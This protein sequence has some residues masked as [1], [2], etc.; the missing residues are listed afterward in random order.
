MELQNLSK[1]EPQLVWKHFDEIRKTPRA[2]QQEEAMRQYI[3][4][5]AK[6]NN[7]SYDQD[8]AGNLVVSKAASK[9]KE[10]VAGTVLQTHMDMVCEKNKDVQHDFAKDPIRLKQEGEY[11]YAV[12]TT[13]GADNGIGMAA[14]LAVL[15]SKDLVH[16][17]IECLFTMD[18]E[19]GLNGARGLTAEFIKGRRMLNLDSEEEGTIYIGC[20]GGG[21]TDLKVK[22]DYQ[23]LAAGSEC[24][25]MTI[26]GLQGGHSGVDI[27]IGR[28][29]A[30]ELLVRVIDYL[31]RTYPISV[32]SMQGGD[33]HNAIPR[34]ASARIAVAGKDKAAFVAAVNKMVESIKGEYGKKDPNLA[35][36]WEST[37]PFAQVLTTTCQTRLLGMLKSLPHGV[38]AMNPDIPEL[39]NTSVNFAKIQWTEKECL[40]HCSSRSSI[41]D[42]LEASRYKVAA[43]GALAG[44][45]IEHNEAYPGW[46]PNLESKLL[47]HTKEVYKKIYGK[48]PGIKAIHAGLECGIIGEKV[49]G[50]DMVSIGPQIENPHSP[51]ERVQI[52]SVDKFWKVL[53][54]LLTKLSV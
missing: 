4:R 2:S 8:K 26:K 7:L 33:K 1:L 5:F 35:V 18:E 36:A 51:Q 40:V 11:L 43:I 20:A 27:H 25:Q 24:L 16:G 9:G 31:S 12:G 34:E 42:A 14:A 37:A 41:K 49:T 53:V 46:K 23:P 50:M 47:I 52:A 32:Q 3:I 15:E 44:A 6:A 45:A 22:L 19:T 17:P 28:G 21:G 30:I 48:D 38:L 13:L 39:V 54:S 29:N 10:K